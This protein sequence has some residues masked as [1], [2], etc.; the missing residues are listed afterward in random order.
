VAPLLGTPG[1]RGPGSLNR[2]APGSYAT[3]LRLSPVGH[4]PHLPL[5]DDCS[6][7]IE[8]TCQW[9]HRIYCCCSLLLYRIRTDY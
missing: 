8:L 2:L 4:R 9:C 7:T 6:C 1:A 3:E 5:L